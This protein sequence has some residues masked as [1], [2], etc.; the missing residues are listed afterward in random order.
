MAT[1]PFFYPEH[2]SLPFP[3]PIGDFFFLVVLSDP[4]VQNFNPTHVPSAQLLAVSIFIHQSE[5]I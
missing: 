5:L 4:S 2:S 3:T 1:F